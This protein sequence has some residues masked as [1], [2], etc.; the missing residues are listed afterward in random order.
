MIIFKSFSGAQSAGTSR[1]NIGGILRLVGRFICDNRRSMSHWFD[2]YTRSGVYCVI[3]VR[4]GS[5]VFRQFVHKLSNECK[6]GWRSNVCC[7]FITEF[8]E[9]LVKITLHFQ[10][11]SFHDVLVEVVSEGNTMEVL[12][13]MELLDDDEVGLQLLDLGGQVFSYLDLDRFIIGQEV[14]N[15]I[16]LSFKDVNASVFFN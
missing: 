6:R 16:D 1:T 8:H 5:V 11:N 12:H 4:V 3:E 13:I 10:W 9:T 2:S 14:E 15:L 7:S